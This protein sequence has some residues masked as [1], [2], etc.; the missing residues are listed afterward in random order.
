MTSGAEGHLPLLLQIGFRGAR[1]APARMEQTLAE[2]PAMYAHFVDSKL[3][4][5]THDPLAATAGALKS[6]CVGL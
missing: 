5:E 2:R 1:R 4:A 3:V 6:Q